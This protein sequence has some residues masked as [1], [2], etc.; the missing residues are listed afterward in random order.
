MVEHLLGAHPWRWRVQI[1]REEELL[2]ESTT[3]QCQL[4]NQSDI[5]NILYFMEGLIITVNNQKCP[6]P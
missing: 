5:V 1:S 6:V 3:L 4:L 2:L